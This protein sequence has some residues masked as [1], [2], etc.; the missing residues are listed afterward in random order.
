MSIT[1]APDVA[2]VDAVHRVTKRLGTWTYADQV[3]IRAHYGRTTVDLR[4]PQLPTGE[5]VIDVDVD[6]SVVRLLV[7]EDAVIDDSGLV[8]V[9][10]SPLKDD[11]GPSR[12]GSRRILITGSL[13]HGQIRVNRGGVATLFAIFSRNTRSR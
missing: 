4:S 8:R 5:I 13:R 6:H 11:V 2:H 3:T 12:S 10:R 9:G 1:H 7:P